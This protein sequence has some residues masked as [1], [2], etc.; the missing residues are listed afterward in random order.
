MTMKHTLS[1]LLTTCLFAASAA[2]QTVIVTDAKVV[3][4]ASAG[5]VEQATVVITDG[6]VTQ[7]GSEVTAPEGAQIIDGAG[8]WVTPGLFAP[9]AQ[10]G[11][12]EI[13]AESDTNDTR[14]SKGHTSVSDLAADSFNP[15]SPVI[16]ITRAEGITH[17]AIVA[18]PSHNIFG[19]T[20]SIINMTGGFDSIIDDTAFVFVQL[21]ER[22]ASLAGGSRSAA[23]AQLRAGLDD[24]LRYSTRYAGGPDNG[25]TL[26]RRD[27]SA[28]TRA[29]RG[30][31][32]IVI[33]ADRAVDIL[34]I[35]DLKQDYG[36]LDIIVLGA[37]EGWMVASQIAESYLKVMI[38]PHDNLPSSFDNVAARLDN[39]VLLKAAGAEI[40][41]M[42]RTT[43]FSHNV[44]LLP[45]H[46]G[47]AVGNGLDWDTAFR[48][49]SVTP[50][51]W[52][53]VNAGTIEIGAQANLVVWDGDPLEVTSSPEFIMIGGQVQSGESRQSQLRDRYNPT[54]GETKPHKYR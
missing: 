31:M 50:A 7:I 10:V 47:N 32:P 54:T 3:T 53:D 28:L 12:V 26:S 21:G 25:D 14:A 34:K 5:T 27:A 48:A 30:Q 11:L 51:S 18:S 41:F 42:S 37:A 20:G 49:I 19:G 29:A 35:I 6:R 23:L 15:Q 1:L 4:N 39:A 16:G 24:A 38:D 43:D 13:G 40:A 52:F 46:A 22:G 33:A 2:A 17:A 44:R 8:Q 45:Q 9:F 36:G